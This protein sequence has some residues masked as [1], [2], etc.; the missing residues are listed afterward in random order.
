MANFEAVSRTNY[1]KVKDPK[2]FEAAMV[3]TNLIVWAAADGV[4]GL[5]YENGGWPSDREVN[6]EIEE[7]DLLQTVSAH[8]AEGQV[9]VFMTAGYEKLRYVVGEAYAVDHKGDVVGV[10]LTDIYDLAAKQFGVRPSV[11]EY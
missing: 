3:G 4:F 10:A 5:A 9:A 2:A 8:L 7:F 11:A 1:F 6:D